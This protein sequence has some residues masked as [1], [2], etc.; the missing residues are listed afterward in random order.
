MIPVRSFVVRM[1]CCLALPFAV[2]SGQRDL[3][4]N[5][6]LSAEVWGG[7]AKGRVFSHNAGF[8]GAA[9]SSWRV[10][11]LPHV[12][13]I[14]GGGIDAR[15]VITCCGGDVCY[16]NAGAP[17]CAPDYPAF[18]SLTGHV[19]LEGKW[20][21]TARLMLGPGVFYSASGTAAGLHGRADLATP[22][23]GN[24]ALVL[25][26]RGA[27]LPRFQGRRYEMQAMGIGI[28]VGG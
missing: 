7:S 6:D 11:N 24:V 17:G 28:R 19:G 8:G 1:F 26:W 10:R 5:L 21:G 4:P 3:K 18:S 14:A 22:S 23:V 20:A 9:L 27:M 15:K 16:I 12:T 2:A 13:I 25:S